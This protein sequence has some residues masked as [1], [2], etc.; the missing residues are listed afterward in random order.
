M[1]AE[2]I[3]VRGQVQ[4]VGFRPFVWRL[5]AEFGISG[6]VRNDGEGV[7]IRAFAGDVDGFV[8]A[9]GKEP[10][11]LA[12]IDSIA[13]APLGDNVI[14]PGFSIVET[15]R[16][17]A[18]TGATPDAAMCPACRA[19]ILDPGER[20]HRYA[21][22]NCTHC[23]P[24]FSILK[25]IPYDRAST[26]MRGFEMCPACRAEYEDPADRRFHAQPI[27]CPDCGP[28]LWLERDGAEI[29]GDAIVEAARLLRAGKIL[30]IKGIGGFHLACDAANEDAVRLLRERK[31]RPKKPF[32]LMADVGAIRRHARVSPA[33]EALLN[34]PAAP[35]VLLG[36]AGDIPLAAALAPGLSVLGWMLPYTP[37]HALLMEA[38]GAPLVMTSGNRSGEPQAIGNDEARGKLG[39]FIDAFLMHDRPIARRLDDSVVRIVAGDIRL[40]RRARGYAP[41]PLDLPPGLKSAPPV[42]AYGGELKSALCLT[43]DGKAILSHHLGDLEDALSYEEF[44]KAA[45]DYSRLFD[46]SPEIVAADLHPDYRSTQFAEGEAERLGV[47]LT[48]VQHHHAHIASAMA[49]NG[50]P[51]DGA[52]VLGVALDG[53]GY[54][55]D[56]TVWGGE[57]LAAT[58]ADYRRL[59]SLKPVPLAGGDAANREPWRNL[60][61]QLEA[62]MGW[63]VA[64]ERLGKSALSDLLAAK[65]VEN[66]R[67]LMQRRLNSPL[68]SSA[69][70]LF[71]AV[72]AAL[73]LAVDR[74]TYEGEAAMELEALA[75]GISPDR[76]YPFAVVAAEDIR[77]LDPAPMWD[78][79]LTDLADSVALGQISA[80]F[81]LGLAR[82]TAHLAQKLAGE[83]SAGAIALSGGVFQ[84]ALLLRLVL[85]ELDGCGLPVLAQREV[86]AN[87]GGLAFGQV[88]V[89][90]ARALR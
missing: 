65:P 73:G 52:P 64:A 29:D 30:G 63:D 66:L 3:R 4:G 18:R 80:R 42:A 21:F 77:R 14:R 19:E 51:L 36:K 67:T 89:A 49:E 68:T 26:T 7:L 41:A 8:A 46:H 9:L 72:G 61:A 1:A 16:S 33:E 38:V 28:R 57:F 43:R 90:A 71:D 84:N 44:Q 48:R 35:I 40:L 86:P 25:E 83:I 70:R 56:G 10:P 5:A 24:R 58:Y 27:A 37:L 6:D 55:P 39:P 15:D 34:D 31:R 60:V 78:A 75:A 76:A 53:L 59:A 87:D 62:A 13:R 22:A 50:W 11:P 23:G 82:A 20:R 88:A 79:L 45:K 74:L 2:K 85:E 54:G 81:H 12:R 47:P 69:G 17:E 32:A